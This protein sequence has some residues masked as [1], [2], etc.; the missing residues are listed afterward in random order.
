MLDTIL[1]SQAADMLHS[2]IPNSDPNWRRRIFSPDYIIDRSKELGASVSVDLVRD[3]ESREDDELVD[4]L[5]ENL[6]DAYDDAIVITD[7]CLGSSPPGVP[8]VDG[9]FVLNGR[10]FDDFVSEYRGTLTSHFVDGDVIIACPRA[11]YFVIF[12]HE[13]ALFRIALC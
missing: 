5:G 3:W 11:R 1:L 8:K 10:Q 7:L 13:G 9:A 12:H 2:M 6:A 4:A